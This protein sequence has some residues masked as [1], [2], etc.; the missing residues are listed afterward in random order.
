[1]GELGAWTRPAGEGWVHVSLHQITEALARST[2][3]IVE[4]HLEGKRVGQLAPKMSGEYLPVIDLLERVGMQTVARAIVKGNRLKADVVLYAA[5][6]GELDEQWLQD[7]VRSPIGPS[8]SPDRP[9]G[10]AEIAARESIAAALTAPQ[11]PPAGW[12]ADPSGAGGLRWW[13]G[14]AWTE[15]THP[16]G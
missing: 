2:R 3:E 4:V 5:K 1:M 7:L 14:T 9:Q 13:N 10:V 8:V 11:V 6:A 16:A 12:F 15:H